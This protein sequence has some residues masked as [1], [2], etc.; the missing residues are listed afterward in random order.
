MTVS[1]TCVLRRVL[2]CELTGVSQAESPEPQVGGR[3]GDAAQAELYSVDGLMQELVC[4]VKLRESRKMKWGKGR[5]CERHKAGSCCP[6][7]LG[8]VL[9]A[10]GE[11]AEDAALL[12]VVSPHQVELLVI[13]VPPNALITLR[14]NSTLNE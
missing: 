4:K 6:H 1:T 5:R 3:V 10:G 13:A 11:V 2:Y 7:L 14:Q 9:P 12:H 8:L